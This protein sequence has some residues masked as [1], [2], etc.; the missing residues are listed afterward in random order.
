VLTLAT[1][2]SGR[3]Y[4]EGNLRLA[5]ELASRAALAVD[6][7]RLFREA[8]ESLGL[9]DAL[10]ATA[11]VGLAF[12]DR[13]LRYLKI[14]ETL[15][16]LNGVPAAEHVGRTAAEVIPSLADK[17]EPL[18]RSVLETGQ[19]VLGEE[20]RG[21]TAAMP[22]ERYWLASYYPVQSGDGE[23]IGVGAVVADLTERTRAQLRL[24]AQYQVTR[25]LSSVATFEEAAEQV[26]AAMCEN[27]DWA[28]AGIWTVADDGASLRMRDV[29]CAP[30]FDGGSFVDAS[31]DLV[32]ELGSGLPGHVAKTARAS[33]TADLQED[34]HFLRKESAAAA[35]LRSGFAFPIFL[36]STV[37]GVVEFFSTE[38]RE[39]DEDLLAMTAALGS[40][41]GQFI[42]R[43]R[44]ELATERARKRL[45]FLA[46]AS[47]VLSSSLEFDVTLQRIT[48]L[49]VPTLADWCGVS[50]LDDDG[51]LRQ[52]AI[53][54]VDP[55]KIRWARELAER[56][57]A[58]PE[59]EYGTYA[60]VRSQEPILMPVIS[61]EL[62]ESSARDEDHLRIIQELQARSYMAAPLVVRDRAVGVIAF[63][64]TAESERIYDQE[65][66][67]FA[68]ELAHRA[69][70]A[71]ENAELFQRALENEEQQRFLA[72][73]GSAL[74]SSLDYHDTLQRVASL[75]LPAFAD[76][77]I[78]DVLEGDEI[79]RVAAAARR[80]ES[81]RA[82]D[83]LRQSYVPTLDSP[84]P[85][86]LALREGKPVVF[87]D[88]SAESLRATTRDERH[89]E[90]MEQLM[91]CSAMALPMM[92]RGHVVGAM[93]FAWAESGRRYTDADLPLAEE[94]ARRAGLAVDNARL[95]RETEERARAAL[96]LTH[97][98]DGVFMID[99]DGIVRLWNPAA[100]AITGLAASRVLGGYADRVIPGW[101]ELSERIPIAAEPAPAARR[102]E[103]VPL[104]IGGREL[105]LSI[106]G[107]GLP[108]GTV[109]AF[110]DLTEE[111]ALERMRSD[112]VA[113]ISH[114]LRTP[115]ASVYGAAVTLIQRDE[116]L[117]HDHRTRLLGVIASEAD[118]LARIVNDV[119]LASRLDSQQ[120]AFQI[121]S[122]DAGEALDRSIDAARAHLPAGVEIVVEQGDGSAA[123]AADAEKL[124]QILGNLIENAVKYSPDGGVIRAGYERVGRRLR[125]SVADQGIG[126]PPDERERI[127]EKF[128]RLDP[129]LLRGV[130]GTGL[131]LYIS[132]EL[133]ER[134]HGA[135]WVDSTL[136]EGSTFYFELPLADGVEQV[137]GRQRSRPGGVLVDQ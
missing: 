95:H 68:E 90:L 53:A 21:A 114:E 78:V 100:E 39:P 47:R 131:G 73:A 64:T 26:L 51:E 36:G 10:F 54:H 87:H 41:I 4:D 101:A 117:G 125:Y 66:L 31:R 94:I 56:Y 99:S 108:E 22:E 118:R 48:E 83:E 130:G 29:Y 17:V 18:L 77:C 119:L 106:T 121:E 50:M 61:P 129:N 57:P 124:R 132:R 102:A 45:T 13:N 63:L 70:I 60:V 38:R 93:T 46:E 104:E 20:L 126:I 35:G 110:R 96:V 105:W 74:A 76:W 75:A 137:P 71:V 44:A 1:A 12:F 85:A 136:G 49:A 7:A 52:V 42:E 91:P 111:R 25:I 127:F 58:D 98:G 9:L 134:M 128:Y 27:L 34:A 82:L 16:A 88:F 8:E 11:P 115:L 33:W 135:I 15:A 109:Y 5:E 116:T 103:T 69:G 86:A 107:V 89:F 81:Q 122:C 72:E 97:V 79:H 24:A 120:L 123:V 3:R 37:F 40:Q 30:G 84:Q 19:P 43:T 65:D 32:L 112:F 2:E 28:V 133:A 67:A 14:N 92:A 23:V 59:A 55:D 62:L 113:T 6:N 80:E